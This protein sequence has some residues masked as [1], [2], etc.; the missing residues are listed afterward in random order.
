M[1][2]VLGGLASNK[3]FKSGDSLACDPATLDFEEVTSKSG[4]FGSHKQTFMMPNVRSEVQAAYGEKEDFCVRGGESTAFEDVRAIASTP[5]TDPTNKYVSGVGGWVARNGENS[6]SGS[7]V[8]GGGSVSGSRVSGSG[9][10][11]GS[12]S[13]V[14]GCSEGSFRV[15]AGREEKED[16]DDIVAAG[17]RFERFA[18]L[19]VCPV[20]GLLLLLWVLLE[21]VD[22]GVGIYFKEQGGH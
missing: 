16:A 8:R 13:E 11:G 15:S 14:S 12:F 20:E 21:G 7:S 18:D 3:R 9:V 22:E 10:S 1:L 2:G 17:V 4:A 5:F 6:A 19:V